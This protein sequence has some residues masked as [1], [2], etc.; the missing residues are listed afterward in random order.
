MLSVEEAQA[1]HYLKIILK[2]QQLGD[3]VFLKLFSYIKVCLY[4]Q[5]LFA[6]EP[7]LFISCPSLQSALNDAQKNEGS[8]WLIVAPTELV[9]KWRGIDLKRNGCK[10]SQYTVLQLLL[11]AGTSERGA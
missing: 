7:L 11:V 4:V 9:N 10:E 8:L 5:Y 6:Y 3:L 1:L 2:F